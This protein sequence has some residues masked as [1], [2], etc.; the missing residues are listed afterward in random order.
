MYH[1]RSQLFD[2]NL[3]KLVFAPLRTLM[4][5]KTATLKKDQIQE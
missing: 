5:R 3:E 2:L 1:V 4:I